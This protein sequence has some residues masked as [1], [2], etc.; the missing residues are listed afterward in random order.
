[1][2]P[3]RN[4]AFVQKLI[5]AFAGH[6]VGCELVGEERFRLADYNLP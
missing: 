4:P 2:R 1:M 6:G 5:Q 3:G